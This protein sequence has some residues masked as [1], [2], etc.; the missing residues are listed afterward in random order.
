MGRQRWT[1]ILIILLTLEVLV[2]MELSKEEEIVPNSYNPVLECTDWAYDQGDH[3]VLK[4][5]QFGQWLKPIT[6]APNWGY[7]TKIAGKWVEITHMPI[8]AYAGPIE[9]RS[10]KLT[11]YCLAAIDDYFT[12]NEVRTLPFG[13]IQK[14]WPY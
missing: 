10:T 11:Q 2:Y 8:N 4:V 7:V 3:I 14:T 5:D 13:P 1:I 6:Q 12:N 9:V